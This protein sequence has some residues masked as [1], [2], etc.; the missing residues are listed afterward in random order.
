MLIYQ[1]TKNKLMPSAPMDLETLNHY[2]HI[3]NDYV[4]KLGVVY[5]K[6]GRKIC[7]I[8]TFVF[9]EKKE[10]ETWRCPKCGGTN[11]AIPCPKN[12]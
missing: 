2:L 9:T 4:N 10:I 8:D 7:E 11:L 6:Q 1:F 5:D 3:Q 12:D